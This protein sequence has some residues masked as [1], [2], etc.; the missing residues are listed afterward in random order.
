M[1]VLVVKHLYNMVD[2]MIQRDG[3]EKRRLLR[4]LPHTRPC[5][6]LVI[7]YSASSVPNPCVTNPCL[8]GGTC[9]DTYSKYTGFPKD[10]DMG[11][12]HYYCVC[13]PEYSGQ[14]CE[15]GL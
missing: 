7:L 12:L 5:T 2:V 9:I 13:P 14:K 15:G 3:I 4:I 10:W 8:H 1:Q 6:L 11:Y